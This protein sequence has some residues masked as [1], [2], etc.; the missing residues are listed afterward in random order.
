MGQYISGNIHSTNR[1]S[2]KR[3]NFQPKRTMRGEKD[4]KQTTEAALPPADIGYA[5]PDSPGSGICHGGRL[6]GWIRPIIAI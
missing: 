5:N 1:I 6:S 2:Q 4:E 3:L